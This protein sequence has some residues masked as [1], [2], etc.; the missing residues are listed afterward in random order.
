MYLSRLV[1]NPRNRRVQRELSNLYEL[2]RSLLRFFPTPLPPEERILF[3]VDKAAANEMIIVL[4]QS[5]THPDWAWLGDPEARGYL[6]HAPESKLF[7]PELNSG[8]ILVFRLRANP[9][10][11]H[12]LPKDK[13]NPESSPKPMRIPITN[14]AKQRAWLERKASENGFHILQVT[15]TDEGM[16]YGR[17]NKEHPPLQF[18][19]IRYEGILQVE[20]PSTFLQAIQRGIGPAKGFGFGL[21]SIAPYN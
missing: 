10:E 20:D 12:W 2:H 21:L 15:L 1:L 3:R 9:T 16:L 4:L 7:E 14:E 13:N 19:S 8:Q 6:L 5:I 17:A 18:R 11:K